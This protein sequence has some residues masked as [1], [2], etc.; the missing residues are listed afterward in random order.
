MDDISSVV[1]AG[2]LGHSGLALIQTVLLL[3]NVTMQY[4]YAIQNIGKLLLI[5]EIVKYIYVCTYSDRLAQHR[6]WSG[7]LPVG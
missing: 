1:Y 2:V 7:A 6:A 3:L 4:R 5:V